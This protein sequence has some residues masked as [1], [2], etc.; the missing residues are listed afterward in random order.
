MHGAMWF[1]PSF[2]GILGKGRDN[3]KEKMRPILQLVVLLSIKRK[4]L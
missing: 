1:G 3:K 2:Q 4:D